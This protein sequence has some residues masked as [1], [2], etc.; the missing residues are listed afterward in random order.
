VR[1]RPRARA[2]QRAIVPRVGPYSQCDLRVPVSQWN[3]VQRF[4]AASACEV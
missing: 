4:D 3:V 2:P 1:I